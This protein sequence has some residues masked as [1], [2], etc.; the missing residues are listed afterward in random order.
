MIENSGNSLHATP[1][2]IQARSLV[3]CMLNFVHLKI[4]PTFSIYLSI[5]EVICHLK[6]HLKRGWNKCYNP[7]TSGTLRVLHN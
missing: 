2:V 4:Q 5:V 3:S 1:I 7:V 6:I